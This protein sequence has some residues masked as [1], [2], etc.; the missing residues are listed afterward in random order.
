MTERL[1]L[2]AT[3]LILVLS[4]AIATAQDDKSEPDA[5]RALSTVGLVVRS[6]D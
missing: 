4:P 5:L 2:F 1:H 3:L 6:D